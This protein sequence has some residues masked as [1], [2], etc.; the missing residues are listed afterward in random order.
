MHMYCLF[1]MCNVHRTIKRYMC[2]KKKKSRE[3]NIE[4]TWIQCALTLFNLFK[5]LQFVASGIRFF[6]NLCVS[7]FNEKDTLP[8]NRLLKKTNHAMIYL[9]FILLQQTIDRLAETKQKKN[10]FYRLIQRMR[11]KECNK[12]KQK[13]TDLTKMFV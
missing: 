4:P 8:K 3:K 12:N 7:I 10:S 13:K 5:S 1:R 6:Q 2:K 11:E 9:E